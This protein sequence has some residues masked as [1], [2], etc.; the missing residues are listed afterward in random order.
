MV[1]DD[2]CTACCMDC[3]VVLGI[4][5]AVKPHAMRILEKENRRWGYPNARHPRPGV[6]SEV[7]ITLFRHLPWHVVL[8]ATKCACLT[9]FAPDAG[10]IGNGPFC[11]LKRSKL[12]RP[13]ARGPHL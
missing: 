3:M 2:A 12:H 6:T 4:G 11:N 13:G 7:R 8:S 9:G 5:T 10:I 1:P